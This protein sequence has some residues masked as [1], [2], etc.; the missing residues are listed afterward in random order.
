MA[1]LVK[2]LLS[3]HEDLPSD[4]QNP[5]KKA[6]VGEVRSQ[7]IPLTPALGENV[8]RQIPGTQ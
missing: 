6:W 4:H 2:C 3:R 5:C 8:D 7:H 1:Q